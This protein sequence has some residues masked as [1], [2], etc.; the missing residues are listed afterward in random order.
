MAMQKETARTRLKNMIIGIG[1]DIVLI[2][3]IEKL[4][5]EHGERFLRKV[6]SDPEIV[7]GTT[8][9]KSAHFFAGRFAAREAFFKALGTG[10][11]RGLTLKEVSVTTTDQGQ[12]NLDLSGNIEQFLRSKGINRSHLSISHDGDIAQAIVIL[13]QV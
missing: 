13:E 6:F 1:I 12:P 2:S 11:G 3:R 7:E 10:W 4:V 5:E 8:K 9:R